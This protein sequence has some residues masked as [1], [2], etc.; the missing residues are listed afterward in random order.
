MIAAE[1]ARSWHAS[2]M[3]EAIG[4]FRTRAKVL[5]ALL[6]VLAQGGDRALCEATLKILGEANRLLSPLR[7]HS[8]LR[9][10]IRWTGELFPEEEQRSVRTVLSAAVLLRVNGQSTEA[11]GDERGFEDAILARV[12]HAAFQVRSAVAT[13]SGEGLKRRVI[14]ASIESKWRQARRTLRQ[15][16]VARDIAALHAVRKE[17]VA[18]VGCVDAWRG[19]SE[20]QDDA[21]R[22]TK[23][24]GRVT[25]RIGEDRDFAMLADRCVLERDRF[26]S[27]ELLS[28]ILSSIAARRKEIRRSVRKDARRLKEFRSSDLRTMLR[29]VLS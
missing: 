16:L 22:L 17:L 29:E 10:S 6:T 1:T 2:E 7:D 3:S 15:A 4:S 28:S 26:V 8:V 20:R 13:I 9:R 11:A 12:L 25:R 18:V 27:Q 19:R 14:A 21:A 23:L 24:V 5:R